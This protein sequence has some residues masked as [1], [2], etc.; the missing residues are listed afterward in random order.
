MDTPKRSI[1][2]ED[3]EDF[4][5]TPRPEFEGP[6]IV[7]NEADERATIAKVGFDRFDLSSKNEFL[8]NR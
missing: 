2:S 1:V 4:E 5:F 7:F 8:R 3:V 6:F